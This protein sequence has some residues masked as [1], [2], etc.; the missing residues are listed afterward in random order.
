MSA[1]GNRHSHGER[2]GIAPESGSLA[3]LLESL[4]PHDH[5]CL[6]Y[7]SKEEWRVVAIPF[8]AIGLKR[9]EK[10]IYVVDTSTTHEIRRY[11]AEEG[12]DVASVEQ[13]GQLAILH[14]TE[15][16]T[17][18]GSFDPDRMIALL[19]EETER[20]VADGYPALRVTG[21]MTWVLHGHHGSEKAL[22]YEAKLN[23][24][25]F[26]P[27]P[28]LVVCQYDRRQF[29]PEV[30]KGVIMT[31]PLLVRGNH[32]Y[33]NFYYVPPDEFLSATRSAR[34]AQHWLNN[35]ERERQTQETLRAREEKY[36][37]LFESSKEAIVLTT[38]DGRFLEANPAFLELLGY[39]LEDL[40]NLP[41]YQLLVEGPDMGAFFARLH[42]DGQILDHECRFRRDDGT[43]MDCVATIVVQRN[44]EGEVVAHHGLIRDVTLQKQA[45][46]E[47][48]RSRGELRRIAAHVQ[49][50]R[51]EED[52]AV[53]LE[54]HD[55]VGQALATVNMDLYSLRGKLP[56]ETPVAAHAALDRIAGA[57]ND[58]IARLRRLYADLKPGMLEDLGLA[59]AI[60]WQTS[61]FA[62]HSGIAC[63]VMRLDEVTLPDENCA[64]AMY[65]MFREALDNVLR[66]SGATKVEV[67]VEQHARHATVRICDNGCGITEEE[68]NS[69]SALGL[70]AMYERMRAC[71][72][73]LAIRR[74]DE[75]G[76]VVEAT[77]PL[78]DPEQGDQA[79]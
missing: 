58:A 55:E 36:R 39:S 61:E 21:E 24:D 26:P 59:A 56:P 43:V 52:S 62:G 48:E 64:L 76:T 4:H 28:C 67:S 40:A 74:G 77:V 27:H 50:V 68:L 19:I 53:A 30:I 71:G 31:H 45:Q 37:S 2:H 13:S 8:I 38:P 57:L 1:T 17:I 9:G 5:L 29:D 20:A 47:I 10:C 60:E 34:E 78:A 15:A 11:L 44:E 18:E 33:H 51:E 54:L 46:A 7:E 72:G 6:I 75:G 14:E 63:Q 25:L 49:F 42:R 69:P 12:I 32:I 65:R 16:Y 41:M 35:L 79:P 23:R 3:T 70:A 66:H 73:T 22:E